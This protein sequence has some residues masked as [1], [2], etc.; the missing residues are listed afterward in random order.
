M[1]YA[2]P[3]VGMVTFGEVNT[4]FER[5]QIKHDEAVRDLGSLDIDLIDAGIV[6]DDPAYKTA[7]AAIARLK[8]M[9]FSSLIVCVAG[10]VPTHAVIRV[11]D[12]F[13]NLPMVLWGLCGWMEN[14]RLV[15]TADQAGTTAIRPV[16]EAMGYRFRYVYSVIG[17]EPPLKKIDSFLR[18]ANAAARLRHARIGS[19]GYRDMLL[20]GTQFEGNSLRGQLGVEVEP[21]EMLEMVQNIEQ[22]NYEDVEKLV[23]EMEK[24]WTYQL[25]CD[26]EVL[27]KGAKYALA[28]AKRIRERGYEAVTLIDVDGMKKL[29]GYPPAIVFMLLEKL[30]GVM[31][32]PE[33]DVMG[34][35]TQLILSYLT[36]QNIHYMEYYEFFEDSM[37]IGTPDYVPAS[38]VKGDITMLPTAFGLLSASLLNVS[39]VKDGYVTCARLYYKKGRYY[40]HLYTG[41]ARQPMA[42]QE[43]GWTD[44]IPQLCSLQVFP[45]SCTVEEFAQHVSSQHVLLAYGNHMD[46]IEQLCRLLDIEVVK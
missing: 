26:R 36:G 43:F 18:A 29:M 34:N 33:N 8:G 21:F 22:L 30:C 25:P 10:W 45:D 31:T 42:W 28:L 7:T 32:T 16:L 3:V 37:L 14:G 13:R 9:E 6:I 38:A 4:P 1:S 40:M 15:T 5:L 11:T 17:K 20:Y 19:M 35:V 44:P 2:R 23:A 41:E 27:V 24:E 39:K 12:A 46:E